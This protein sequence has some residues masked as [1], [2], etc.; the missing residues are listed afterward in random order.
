ME[1]IT[2]AKKTYS[3]IGASLLVMGLVAMLISYL[4]S[5]LLDTLEGRGYDVE[6]SWIMWVVT[7]V[8]LYGIGIPV[9]LLIL[10]K[11]P[12]EEHSSQKLSVKN[13]FIFMLMCFPLMYGGNIIGNILSMILSGGNAQ[14]P[15][16]EIAFD[17]NF[18]KVVVMVILGPLFEEWVFRREIIDRCSR[19]GEKAAILFSALAFGLFHMNLYQFFYAFGLGLVF[20]YVY[21]RTRKLI[22]PYI[23]HM[24]I[25]F[26][27]G[28]VAP[29]ILSTLDLEE[30]AQMG[31]KP[32]DEAAM[33]EMMEMMPQLMLFMLY[34]V[35]LLG[36]AIAGLVLLIIKAK[37]LVFVTAAEELPKEEGFKCVY[38]NAGVV[39][40]VI[41]C[42]VMCV[43]SLMSSV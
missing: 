5:L 20:G 36:L 17:T 14:N 19:F 2:V 29:W 23:M 38:C 25:N 24:V 42:L 10:R 26:I 16:N 4:I 3:R 7:F 11:L 35:L 37:K 12:R 13:F 31:V 18:L 27:G 30:L 1:Q 9:G 43:V 40:L 6:A 39:L 33:M 22:Y 28:V 34:A 8:P 32:M 15:L 41:Y 21:T